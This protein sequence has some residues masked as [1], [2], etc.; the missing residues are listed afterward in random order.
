MPFKP[1]VIKHRIASHIKLKDTTT[2][3]NTVEKIIN[4]LPGGVCVFEISDKI[5]TRYVSKG[6]TYICG[7]SVEE[8]LSRFGE[9][10]TLIVYHEDVQR[11]TKSIFKC[12]NANE[13]IDVEYHVNC[14][15]G[16]LGYSRI[17]ANFA[18]EEGGVAVY[19][20]VIT[21]MTT[22]ELEIRQRYERERAFIRSF[23]GESRIFFECDLV[24]GKIIPIGEKTT[25]SINLHDKIASINI[26]GV[27]ISNIIHPEDKE[28]FDEIRNIDKVVENILNGK[29]ETYLEFRYSSALE[30][31]QGYRWANAM[32]SYIINPETKHPHVFA[33]IRDINEQKIK[34]ID[35]MEKAQKDFLTGLFNRSAFQELAQKSIDESKENS[36]VSAF[37]II[38]ID[39]F[40]KINDTFGHVYGDVVLKHTAQRLATVFRSNDI[41][42]RLGGDEMTVFMT[43]IPSADIA[44]K[45]GFEICRVLGSWRKDDEKIPLTCSVGVAVMPEHGHT[46]EKLY[47]NADMALYQ[48]KHMGKN[49]CCLYDEKANYP[50]IPRG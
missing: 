2:S 46:L 41:L 3:K 33:C 9:D 8:Y 29:N 28:L 34:D 50:S 23:T 24:T 16:D 26:L 21:D 18:Y 45:K 5:R 6:L 38:D 39:N 25:K 42:G 10:M 49:M 12:K 32:F 40:K 11:V 27:A 43:N 15:N 30:T 22:K 1:T 47:H 37:L 35:M 13:S 14:K 20:G 31:F 44:V 4:N 36:G 48:A 7:Y 17:Q 19:Y